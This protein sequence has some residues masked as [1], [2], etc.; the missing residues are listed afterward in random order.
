LTV[1]RHRLILKAHRH[2]QS[3]SPTSIINGY[4]QSAVWPA[5]RRQGILM[6][7]LA[8]SA[9]GGSV[10]TS[11]NQASL[12]S[13]SPRALPSGCTD[14][15]PC[16]LLAGPYVSFGDQ[17]F[18][19]GLTFAL[20]A[21]GWRSTELDRQEVNLIPPDRPNDRLFLWTDL[22]AVKS[23]GPGHGG[24]VLNTVGKTANALVAWLTSNPDFRVIASPAPAT[25]GVGIMM[26]TLVVG[27][28]STAQYG[29]SSCPANPRCADLFTKP[30]WTVPYGI[31]GDE[32]ARLYIAGVAH[33]FFVVLD[34]T[35]DADL[36]HLA[37][38]A[39]PIINSLRLPAGVVSG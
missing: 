36:A 21:P 11:T 28:S 5:I 26:T 3:V 6:V 32:E 30:E 12:G 2:R 34:A 4:K 20:P 22:V 1:R 38:E 9:C 37:S 16:S 19:A 13:P 23:T 39:A 15:A 24:T 29:D 7:A 18:V 27:V 14:M 33:T 8:A 31:G 35:N 25:I 17:S 10:R